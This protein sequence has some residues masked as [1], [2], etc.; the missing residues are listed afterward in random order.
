MNTARL[1]PHQLT[2]DKKMHAPDTQPTPAP[3][4]QP[5]C[6]AAVTDPNLENPSARSSNELEIAHRKS[7]ITR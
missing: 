7:A 4:R 5:G 2:T 3:R 1:D 6:K